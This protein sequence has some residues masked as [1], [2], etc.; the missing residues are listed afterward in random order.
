MSA[1]TTG[2]CRRPRAGSRPAR[3]RARSRR[4]RR[5]VVGHAA[6]RR[7][8]RP[9][10]SWMF[11]RLLVRDDHD[12]RLPSPTPPVAG[13]RPRPRVTPSTWPSRSADRLRPRRSR[14][15]HLDR[16]QRAGRDATVLEHLQRVVRRTAVASES[17]ESGPILMPRNGDEQQAE[18]GQ[19]ARRRRPSGAARPAAPRR[20]SR[21]V[22]VFSCRIL[23]QSTRGPMPPRIAGVR[24]SDDQHAGQRDQHA[25]DADAAHERHRAA[26]PAPAG[27]SPP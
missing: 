11:D 15:E 2:S 3:C 14:D 27:R 9:G 8:R 25:A 5:G 10:R 17:S 12:D 21:R 22:G 6:S 26:R 4:S 23:G 19:G 24:V 13:R 7:R 20:S 18:H 16:G 1:S